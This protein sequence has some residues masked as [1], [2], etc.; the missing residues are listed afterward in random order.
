M[1]EQ[2]EKSCA[3][4]F[5]FMLFYEGDIAGLGDYNFMTVSVYVVIIILLC[6]GEHLCLSFSQYCRMSNNT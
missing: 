5:L 6:S 2:N 1:L 3:C 4:A